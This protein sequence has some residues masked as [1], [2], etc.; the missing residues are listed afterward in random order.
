V[1]EETVI[2]VLELN[3]VV[4]VVKLVVE[5]DKEEKEGVDIDE[6]FADEVAE[7]VADEVVDEVAEEVADEVVDEV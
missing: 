7:E 4:S 2:F 1:V 3:K 5:L 6:K